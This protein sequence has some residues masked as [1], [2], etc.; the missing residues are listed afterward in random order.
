MSNNSTFYLKL[1]WTKQNLFE[2]L[3]DIQS[4][5][6]DDIVNLYG[7]NDYLIYKTTYTPLQGNLGADFLRELIA[8]D[9]IIGDSIKS[10]DVFEKKWVKLSKLGLGCIKADNMIDDDYVYVKNAYIVENMKSKIN[11]YLSNN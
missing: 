9:N 3:D 8:T 4:V 10:L 6:C 5:E 1:E 11:Q 2:N 7:L